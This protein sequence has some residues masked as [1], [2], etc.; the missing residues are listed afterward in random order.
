MIEEPKLRIRCR[1]NRLKGRPHRAGCGF[2]L[3][4]MIERLPLD[5]EVHEL[6]CPWCGN[7]THV[8]RPASS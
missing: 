5:G 1:G 6:T 3:T 2:D 8:R 7:V 4:E